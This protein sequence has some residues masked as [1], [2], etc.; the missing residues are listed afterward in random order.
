MPQSL[1]LV[2]ILINQIAA[3]ECIERPSSVVK[4]LVE[5]SIDA[6]ATDI[7]IEIQDAGNSL[8][9]IMDNGCGMNEDDL[10]MALVSHATSKLTNADDLFNI[11]TLGFRGE[12]LASIASIEKLPFHL[13]PKIQ[14]Q[15]LKSQQKMDKFKIYNLLL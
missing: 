4:E 3:G 11:H 1:T 13:P 6:G 7:K 2:P 9:Q 10:K 14:K 8:I 15:V 12:A 5:N